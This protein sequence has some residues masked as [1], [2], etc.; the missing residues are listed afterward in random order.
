MEKKSIVILHGWGLRGSVYK[1]LVLILKKEGYSVYF[2]D[3]PGFGAES[4]TK[5]SMT[6][7]DYV[8]FLRKFIE[9]NKLKKPIL[10]G[11][12]FGG[13]VA[14]KYA[15]RN[16]QHISK[17]ILTGVPVIRNTSFRKKIAFLIAV[18]GGK[19]LKVFNLKI[20][21]IGK[22]ILYRSISEWDY[23]NAGPLRQ[24]FKNIIGEELTG[25]AKSLKMPVI[26]VW[27]KDD[28]IVPYT[29]V[30]KIKKIISH[31]QPVVVANT[32]HRLPYL[33]SKA[34]YTAIKNFL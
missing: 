17:L 28:R 18:V 23:Y 11:H 25:Y 1:N 15:W 12:S 31:A 32:G 5:D 3:L 30:E 6:L 19:I 33:N 10:I 26:L 4:L 7:D 16:P 22:K 13:R 9:K 14:I 34:F 2:P 29:D 24:V 8:T 27:G 20:Q 21:D